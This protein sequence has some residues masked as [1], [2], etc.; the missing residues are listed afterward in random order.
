[1]KNYTITK[2]VTVDAVNRKEVEGVRIQ[3]TATL[4]L[5]WAK[6]FFPDE[7]DDAISNTKSCLQEELILDLCK[8]LEERGTKFYEIYDAL[9][10]VAGSN[11]C[12]VG[13][14]PKR[15]LKKE[16]IASLLVSEMNELF[17]PLHIPQTT[18]GFDF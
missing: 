1:M 4:L 8:I 13:I 2:V 16:D 10:R 18:P 6:T 11:E 14:E 5:F 7:L 15:I 3:C 9:K 17:V 12:V